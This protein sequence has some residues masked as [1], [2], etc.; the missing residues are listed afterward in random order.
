[1]SLWWEEDRIVFDQGD[2]LMESCYIPDQILSCPPL[3]ILFSIFQCFIMI[4]PSEFWRLLSPTFLLPALF[5][6][7]P[8]FN[9]LSTY[10]GL[11][12]YFGPN[13]Y[14]SYRGIASLLTQISSHLS[15]TL[16]NSILSSTLPKIGKEL[17]LKS[18][19][20][21]KSITSKPISNIRQSQSCFNFQ[22]TIIH[23]RLTG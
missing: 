21:D 15:G 9:P 8:E 13:E 3:T 17:S 22:F 20:L 12:L 16:L 23:N 19:F 4:R 5:P 2:S 7:N 14:H 11:Y 1:M 18:S 10:Q 6:W